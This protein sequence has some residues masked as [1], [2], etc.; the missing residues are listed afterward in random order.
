FRNSKEGIASNI[1]ADRLKKLESHGFITS[2][3]YDPLK[4]QKEYSLTEK[5]KDLIPVMVELMLWSNKHQTGLDVSE[6]FLRKA[7]ADREGFIAGI[8]GQL[9]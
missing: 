1:L 6:E 3:V 4:T 5:G 2:K 9:R 7:A 8:R